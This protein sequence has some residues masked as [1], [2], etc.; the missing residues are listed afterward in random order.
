MSTET[1]GQAFPSGLIK[2]SRPIH[3]PGAD[4]HVTDMI[5]PRNHGMTLRDY[6]A[7]KAIQGLL[8][9]SD[10]HDASTSSVLSEYAYKIADAMLK[11]RNKK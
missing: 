1:G 5:E 7:A 8:A 4:F 11:V 9:S 3:D 6:F 10:Q 2:K